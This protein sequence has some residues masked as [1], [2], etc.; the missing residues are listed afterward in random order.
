MWNSIWPGV[1]EDEV[2]IGHVTN[3]VHFRSWISLEM[4]Q[5][6]DRYLAPN[7]REEHADPKL[8]QRVESHPCRGTVAHPRAPPGAAGGVR[9]AAP[10]PCSSSAAA[11]RQS[12]IDAAD[13]VLDPDALTIGFARRF[14]TYKRAALLLR[15]VDRLGRIL[16]DTDRPVQIIF[17]G[18]AHPRDD[19]GKELIQQIV[20]L[21]Q[22]KEFRRR[23][24]L[25]GRLRHG[26]RP[27][28]G[29]GRGR[30]AEHPAAA[31]GSQRHQRHEG[32]RQRRPQSEHARRLVGR[33]LDRAS[34]KRQ[35]IGWAIGRGEHYDNPEYQDQVESAAL[36]D[37]LE[38]DIVPTFYD[39]SAGGVPR[40]W[41]HYMKSSIAHLCP[42][43]NMQ[44]VVK[45]YSA[46]FYNMAHERSGQL[47]LDGA[48][49]ARELAA[50]VARI[51]SVWPQVRIDRLETLPAAQLTVGSRFRM[52]AWI[53]LGS[54]SP[55]EVTVELYMGRINSEG[56]IFD[57][58][59]LPMQ[60]F[61]QP[62]DGICV[63]EA[64]AVPCLRSG[65]QG[66]TVR[67]LPYHRDQTRAVL[68]GAITW[69]DSQV[70]T[71][72]AL[73]LV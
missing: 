48:V 26:R 63:F 61:G 8:W 49:R 16:N 37:L 64:A 25:P 52:R 19:A 40:R 55:E 30:L 17:A 24:G 53:H 3:G 67:V 68:P 18:K 20:R 46:D 35:F 23:R 59:A 42:Q 69:A 31:P 60:P 7:W 43:F 66:Y 6:Y 1:P 4:N 13:E 27:L 2:P 72:T 56:E 38:H 73:H 10:A 41:T 44:R 28:P 22:Q 32:A 21:A 14:A 58:V 71:D 33:S 9:P 45:E 51:R 62:H 29:A 39:R 65:R 47:L 54:L 5:L 70:S 11:L 15:D 12:E 57:G 36:Y 34:R 50:W